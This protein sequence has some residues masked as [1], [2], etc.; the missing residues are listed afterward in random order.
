M[1]H[2]RAISKAGMMG[3]GVG[4]ALLVAV[5]FLMTANIPAPQHAISKELD[6]KA[7]LESKPE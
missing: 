7:F 3:I 2:K 6:A 5:V 1:Q 4:F